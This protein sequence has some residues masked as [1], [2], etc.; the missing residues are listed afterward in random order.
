M[1][2]DKCITLMLNAF[3]V[4]AIL[5]VP[6]I[7]LSLHSW[8]WHHRMYTPCLLTQRTWN[9]THTHTHRERRNNYCH[10]ECSIAKINRI[11]VG[12]CVCGGIRFTQSKSRCVAS[13]KDPENHTFCH[14]NSSIKPYRSFILALQIII[15]VRY[16]VLL[17]RSVVFALLVPVGGSGGTHTKKE[18]K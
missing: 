13:F 5:H 15:A 3:L 11:Y 6:M 7:R 17:F 16:N 2:S 9:H 8:F 1:I 10:S 18:R 14:L 12:E 4:Q